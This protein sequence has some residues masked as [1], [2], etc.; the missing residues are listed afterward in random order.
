MTVSMPRSDVLIVGS[1]FSGIALA[2]QLVR[3]SKAIKIEVVDSNSPEQLGLA[4]RKGRLPHLLNVPAAG[5]SAFPDDPGHFKNWANAVGIDLSDRTFARRADYAN[6]L[7]DLRTKLKESGQVRFLSDTVVSLMPRERSWLAS[8]LSGQSLE[9]KKVVLSYGNVAPAA[10]PC[11]E[12]IVDHPNFYAN[13][14]VSLMPEVVANWKSVCVIGSGLTAVDICL[15]L[16][17]IGF[18][19]MFELVS[20]HGLLPHPHRFGYAPLEKRLVPDPKSNLRALIKA[21]RQ[22]AREAVSQN[23]DWRA[24]MD[25]IRPNVAEYWCALSLHDQLRFLDHVR[26]FWDIHRHRMPPEL[27]ERINEL[28]SSGRLRIHGGMLRQTSAAEGNLSL[29]V[30]HRGGG[31]VQMSSVDA[32]FNCTGSPA[33]IQAWKSALLNNLLASGFAAPHPTRLG[34]RCDANG[35]L[36][37]RDGKVSPG[38]YALGI[39]RRGELWE[40]TAVPDLRIQAARLARFICEQ[41]EYSKENCKT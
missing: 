10:P 18:K 6:Y 3:T 25:A 26:C 1:G 7:C 38:L 28:Q 33:D 39:L 40:S 31:L 32:V 27:S 37:S 14:W 13:P 22:A 29:E 21:F 35:A 36:L 20:R 5:M 9:A 34:L 30:T 41:S 15:Y 4:Y 17:S 2:S 24:V 11:L 23:G 16:D 8:L 12:S 19:G